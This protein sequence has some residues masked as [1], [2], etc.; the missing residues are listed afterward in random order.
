MAGLMPVPEAA[1][2]EDGG[3]PFG[4]H[5]IWLN[6]ADAR[7]KAVTETGSVKQ[8]PNFDFRFGISAAYPSHHFAPLGGRNDVSQQ[9][10]R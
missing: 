2:Y 10:S 7:A 9:Q 6:L 3:L 4:Q 8:F 5:N 1:M